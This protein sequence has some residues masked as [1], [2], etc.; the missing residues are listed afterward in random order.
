MMRSAII[1]TLLAT[2][3]AADTEYP[4]LDVLLSTGETII[5]QTIDYPEGPAKM[6]SAIVTMQPGQQTGWHTHEV[7]LFAYVIEGEITVDYGPDGTKTYLAGDS[8]IEAYKTR[9]NGINTGSG[10][11]RI[12]AVFAGAEGIPNTVSE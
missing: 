12:L 4:P 9:H 3:V 7:P 6:T 11:V 5:G 1:L 8:L 10:I 2:P